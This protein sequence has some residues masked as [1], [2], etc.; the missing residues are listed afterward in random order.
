M[1]NISAPRD[2]NRI[3]VLIGTSSSDGV[4]PVTVYVDPSTHRLKVD[5]AGSSSGTV[6]SVSVVSANGFAGSVA[7]ATTTPAITITTTLGSGNL[8]LS[9]GTGFVAAPLTGTGNVVLATSPTFSGATITTS[10]FNG[11]TVT[12]T[13]GVITITN[14]KTLAVTNTLTLSGTDSTV[15]TF[16]S[17]TATIART[18][19]GQTFTGV[20]NATS[21]NFTTPVL[22]VASA[23]SINFGGTA[24]ANYV[25]G[26]FTPTV[27][28][29]G[30]AGN[31]VPVYSTNTGRYTRIG[32]QVFVSI[33]LTGDGGAEGAGSGVVNVALPIATGASQ[34]GNGL[35]VGLAV[36]NSTYYQLLGNLS[37]GGTTVQ[38]Q[39]YTSVS[40]IANFTGDQQNNA[41]R[42]I[43]LNFFYE[44]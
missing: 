40:A 31:T 41:T 33:L 26:T 23:T 36:N 38:L 13:T 32:N 24:L 42:V 12:A 19:A 43:R 44:V 30:G 16:P 29:Q 21:W 6:T 37:G 28:L 9:N 17:T 15:M 11:L 7:T 4:S 20:S 5:L 8:A 14:A 1:A 39:Y 3:P 10:T 2:N 25:E 27:T 35:L 22:G 18:D 34:P